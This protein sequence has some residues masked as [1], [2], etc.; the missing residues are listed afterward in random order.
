MGGASKFGA[1]MPK[2]EVAF[3]NPFKFRAA[4]SRSPGPTSCSTR[5][6][7]PF[8]SHLCASPRAFLPRRGHFVPMRLT[9]T[10]LW[11]YFKSVRSSEKSVKL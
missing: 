1:F 8:G 4:S 9:N 3:F 7:I 11:L 5:K 6:P 10:P 2:P